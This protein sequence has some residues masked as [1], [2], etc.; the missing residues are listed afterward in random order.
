MAHIHSLVP[1]VDPQYHAG[2]RVGRNVKYPDTEVFQGFNAPSRLEGDVLD[3]EVTGT[4]PLEINGTFYRIQPDHR[5]PPIFE[6]DIHFNGDGAVTAIRIQD[7]HADFKQRFVQTDRYVAET[8]ERRALFG[9]YRNLYTDDELVKGII[10]TASNTNV[11][12]WRGML[13]AMKEDGPPFAMDPATLETIG[14]YDFEGQ[15]RSPT[16]TAHPKFDPVTGDMVCFGYEAGGN[17]CDASND[18]VVYTI[19][20]DGNKTEECWYESPF[21]GMIHDCGITANYLV[22]PLTPLKC[23]FDRLKKGG[24]HWAWDP[25]EDQWYGIVPRR[26]GKP[27]DIKWFRSDNAFHGHTAGCYEDEN[28]DIVFD[29]TVADGNVFFFFPPEATAP[30]SV[31]KRNKLKSETCRWVLDP[32]APSGTRVYP[33]K[34]WNT[35]G[36]F[37]RIDDRYVTKH[38]DHFWQAKIDPSREYDFKACGSPAG[39]LFNCV[40]HYTW[41]GQTEDVYWVGPRSTLQEPAFIPKAGGSEAEGW[42]IALVNRLDVL[43]NDIVILDA[44]NLQAG[45]VA[46]IHLPFKL[47]LGL[48]GNFV[49]HADIAEWEKRRAKDGEVGPVRAA[50]EPLAWQLHGGGSMQNGNG[51]KTAS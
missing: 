40:S 13:L 22:L 19:D 1:Q 24:N 39:G 33:A 48:H 49:D 16:F 50:T 21:C 46:T 15:V 38:Y 5:F 25:D 41:S 47:R 43:R 26:G 32:K 2:R 31:L 6:D 20:A 8:A 30:G 23:S 34:S 36:E 11:V 27:E 37:S 10:R 28:G 4:I 3:L 17:G 45:P 35:S 51:V 9:R 42:L 12:F 44:L 7:G 18:I 14:R 29:L